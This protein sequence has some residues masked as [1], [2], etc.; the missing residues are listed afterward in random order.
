M[1][2][3]CDS[4]FNIAGLCVVPDWICGRFE[5]VAPVP[6]SEGLSQRV[7]RHEWAPH[8][9]APA[10]DRPPSLNREHAIHAAACLGRAGVDATIAPPEV[11]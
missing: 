2:V 8:R 7:M 4:L 1:V 11:A 10:A 5:R 3:V 9:V 6:L